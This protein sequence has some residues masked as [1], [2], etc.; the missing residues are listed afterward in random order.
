MCMLALP[1]RLDSSGREYGPFDFI[2]AYDTVSELISRSVTSV[3]VMCE[4]MSM[5]QL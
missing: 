4:N 5:L 2:Y 3:L 1:I